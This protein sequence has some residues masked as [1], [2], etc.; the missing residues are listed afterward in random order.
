MCPRARHTNRVDH[1]TSC[2]L[3]TTIPCIMTPDT[4]TEP[5]LM[6]PGLLPQAVL[7]ITELTIYVVFQRRSLMWVSPTAFP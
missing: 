7:K 3:I 1:T 2:T 4:A 5:V 6:L